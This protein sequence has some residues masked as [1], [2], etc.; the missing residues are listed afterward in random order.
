MT[1][2][3]P[4]PVRNL[5][6]ASRSIQAPWIWLD[7]YKTRRSNF[8]GATART[9]Y[10]GLSRDMYGTLIKSLPKCS[11]IPTP[12]PPPSESLHCAA[13]LNLSIPVDRRGRTQCLRW[14]RR[15]SLR[16]RGS[17]RPRTA[18]RCEIYVRCSREIGQGPVHD[19]PKEAVSSVELDHH[20]EILK[21]R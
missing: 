2:R 10:H 4:S 12:S 3:S 18:R 8:G 11:Q 20:A 13:L 21:L 1:E 9:S 16:R 17:G 19:Y 5:R 7:G 14:E 6:T 15:R